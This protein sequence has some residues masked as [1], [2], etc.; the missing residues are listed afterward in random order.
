MSGLKPQTRFL[1]RGS[2]LLV[3]L[4]ALWW[5]ALADPMFYLLKGAAA[6]FILI[7]QNPS[8]DY[9]LRVPVETTLPASPQNPTPQKIHSID[10]DMPR[11]DAAAFTFSLPVF[12]SLMLAAP[13]VRR[14]FRPLLLGTAVMSVVELVL[15]L[16]FAH[17]TAWNAAHQIAGVQD[18]AGK[19]IRAF[20]DYLAT[21]VLP[22]IVPVIVALSLHSELRRQIFPWGNVGELAAPASANRMRPAKRR[23]S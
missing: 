10:F 3:S 2:A 19:W 5:F 15:L 16:I 20:G 23:R 6:S 9:T 14:N 7:Q 11:T 21:N 4:L 12:W 17:I 18:A 13:G 22:Y 8:G 1:L